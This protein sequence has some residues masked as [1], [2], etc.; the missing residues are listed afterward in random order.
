[1][2]SVSLSSDTFSATEI[3]ERVGVGDAYVVVKN[4]PTRKGFPPALSNLWEINLFSRSDL[5][6]TQEEIERKFDEILDIVR[7]IRTFSNEELSV[8]VN[9]DEFD[10]GQSVFIDNKFVQSLAKHGCDLELLF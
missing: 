9:C 4:S 6:G 1:M 8:I 10:S 7:T 3:S 5:E 2:I